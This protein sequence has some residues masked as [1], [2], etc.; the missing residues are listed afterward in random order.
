[1]HQIYSISAPLS[2]AFSMPSHNEAHRSDFT[3][4]PPV[5][6]CRDHAQSKGKRK[7][8]GPDSLSSQGLFLIG[9][10]PAEIR[11]SDVSPSGGKPPFFPLTLLKLC[12]IFCVKFFPKTKGGD[13]GSDA[14]GGAREAGELPCVWAFPCNSVLR[15]WQRKINK[16]PNMGT[17][18]LTS[19]P[20]FINLCT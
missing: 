5:K 12:C 15:V 20:E 4:S 2:T 17:F 14:Q 19:F 6:G 13:Q 16:V 7:Q 18:Y 3:T 9:F 11:C 10:K 8:K 1:M